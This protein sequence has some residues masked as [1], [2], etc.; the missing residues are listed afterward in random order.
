MLE[1]ADLADILCFSHAR[2]NPK[3]FKARQQHKN[4]LIFWKRLSRFVVSHVIVYL[5]LLTYDICPS[6]AAISVSPP[7]DVPLVAI[8][9]VWLALL[10][11]VSGWVM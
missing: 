11:R 1:E 9:P 6:A 8:P 10:V 2:D 5:N 4:R 3:A 7:L